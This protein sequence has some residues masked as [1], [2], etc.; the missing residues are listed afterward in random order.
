[1]RTINK[2]V[3]AQKVNMGG[4]FL[5][6]A[7]PLRGI[8]QISPFLLIHHW[9]QDFPGG[10][11]QKQVGVGP[12]PHRGFT[13]VT[14]IFEGSVH[15]RDSLGFEDIIYAGGT[16]WMNSG[17]GIIHSERPGKEIAEN[18]GKF[19]IIQFWVN[20]PASNK[21]DKAFYQPLKKDTM[22]QVVS[23]DKK[24]E[25]GVVA[26][27]FQDKSSPLRSLTPMLVLRIDYT[28]GGEIEIP[29]PSDFNALLYQL[30]GTLDVNGTE[31]S[32][33]DM[34]WFN[35]D[36]DKIVLK[37]KKAGRAILLSGKPIE[38][39]LATYGP[40]VMNTQEEIM[41]AIND[42]QSGKMGQLIEKFE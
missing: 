3:K 7:I 39:S 17:S 36:G 26:G 2:V 35:N 4:I 22:P 18:G 24:F 31:A 19:E 21:M 9:A 14:L 11:K 1:M 16:Q 41:T 29:L 6:Q 40:F 10:Q 33:K 25:I 12:H 34:V 28:E 38:E 37:S 5:D 30:D 8:D 13:P 27:K 42:Y 23:K 20:S 15:H 32:D